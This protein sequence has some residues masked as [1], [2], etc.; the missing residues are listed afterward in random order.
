MVQTAETFKYVTHLWCYI[1]SSGDGSGRA[2]RPGSNTVVRGP[3]QHCFC[4]I[5]SSDSCNLS[6]VVVG[7]F[8]T[9]DVRGRLRIDKSTELTRYAS[10]SVLLTFMMEL[11]RLL[12]MSIPEH[13][14]G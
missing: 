1:S 2:N 10:A 4:G 8:D 5:L 11:I 3:C 14:P 7:M 13:T 6:D 9:D 12:L